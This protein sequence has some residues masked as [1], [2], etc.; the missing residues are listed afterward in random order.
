[1]NELNANNEVILEGHVITFFVVALIG[2][3]TIGLL[4]ISV[5]YIIMII[6]FIL[7]I[8]ISITLPT[9][10]VRFVLLQG[11]IIINGKNSNVIIW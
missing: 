4:P 1:M 7:I 10:K 6:G 2:G 9:Y 5:I 11:Q 3:V 8:F